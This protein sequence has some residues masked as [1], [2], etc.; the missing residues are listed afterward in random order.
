M[1]R[2]STSRAVEADTY[3][4]PLITESIN[5]TT[6]FAPFVAG[7]NPCDCRIMNVKLKVSSSSL[8]ILMRKLGAAPGRVSGSCRILIRI[9]GNTNAM[10]MYV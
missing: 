6:S 8:L 5:P 9:F 1:T 7:R 4:S 3:V 10:Y 2:F